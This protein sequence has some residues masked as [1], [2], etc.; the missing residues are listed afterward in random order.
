MGP[1]RRWFG[2]DDVWSGPSLPLVETSRQYIENL[3]S[4]FPEITINLSLHSC[5]G[6]V[7]GNDPITTPFILFNFAR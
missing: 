2:G 6:F 1:A 7:R 4:P 3:S 5:L